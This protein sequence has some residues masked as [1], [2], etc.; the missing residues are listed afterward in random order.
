MK[1]ILTILAFIIFTVVCVLAGIWWTVYSYKDC[2]MVGHTKTYC[3]LRAG[4]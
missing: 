1:N 3:I 4:K 2:R